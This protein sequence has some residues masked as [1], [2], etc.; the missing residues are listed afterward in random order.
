MYPEGIGAALA[1]EAKEEKD[2]NAEAL[3]GEGIGPLPEGWTKHVV[4]LVPRFFGCVSLGASVTLPCRIAVLVCEGSSR[5]EE[6]EAR[7]AS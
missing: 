1:A 5:I 2:T 4:G 6:I 7:T 3:S